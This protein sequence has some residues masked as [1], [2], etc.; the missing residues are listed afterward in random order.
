MFPIC[1]K[2]VVSQ[3]IKFQ[4]NEQN[5]MRDIFSIV[6]LLQILIY[7]KLCQRHK[8]LITETYTSKVKTGTLD[9][10]CTNGSQ[11][12]SCRKTTNLV[13]FKAPCKITEYNCIM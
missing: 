5:L 7:Y 6:T 11:I 13:L 2:P 9:W 8:S 12:N 4:E 10:F 1:T 3:N